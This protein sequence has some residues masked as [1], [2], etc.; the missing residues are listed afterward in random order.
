MR[1]A[2]I[3]RTSTALFTRLAL[4]VLL[5]P[6]GATESMAAMRR[7]GD[8]GLRRPVVLAIVVTP[9]T[10]TF[11]GTIWGNDAADYTWARRTHVWK[12]TSGLRAATPACVTSPSDGA[13]AQHDAVQSGRGIRIERVAADSSGPTRVPAHVRL[14]DSVNGR[15]I[16]LIPR[17]DSAHVAQ[18]TSGYGVFDGPIGASV[19]GTAVTDSTVWI[20]LSGAFPEGEGAL[21]GLFRMERRTGTYE[22]I[23]DDS[24]AFQEV[25]GFA[26]VGG[27]LWFGTSVAGEYAPHA[28]SG[29]VRMDERSHKWQAYDEKSTPIPDALIHTLRSDGDIL[30]VA[31][32]TGLAV[33]ELRGGASAS[34]SAASEASAPASSA[35]GG[36]DPFARWD[37]TYFVPGFAGDSLVFDVGTKAQFQATV[38]DEE[39]YTFAQTFALGHERLV[40]AALRSAPQDSVVAALFGDDQSARAGAL[41]ADTTLLPILTPM[42][43]APAF[44]TVMAAVA[45]GTLGPRA[46]KAAVDQLRHIYGS[47]DSPPWNQWA[48]PENRTG[49]GRSLI[50]VG[51]STPLVWARGALQAAVR[52]AMPGYRAAPG[53]VDRGAPDVSSACALVSTGRDRTGLMLLVSLA[54]VAPAAQQRD[55]ATAL[56]KYNDRNAWRALVAFA[57]AHQLPRDLVI[58]VLAPSAMD[59]SSV[60]AMSVDLIHGALQPDG[61]HPSIGA[62]G[63]TR[64]L[65][66]PALAPDLIALLEPGK[67]AES[68]VPHLAGMTLVALSGRADAPIDS[69]G[70]P[71]AARF[72]WWKALLKA[73]G[74]KLDLVAANVGDKAAEAWGNRDW[75]PDKKP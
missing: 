24:L 13:P 32:E 28:G 25:T 30:A 8:P 75:P 18:L 31:T 63:A 33:A 2:L 53:E 36:A 38:K 66:L 55:V 64:R 29:I 6:G 11:C 71:P 17:Y 42:L 57:A 34:A 7:E 49:L 9:D 14:R 3:A 50:M 52:R 16:D 5:A 45:I 46:P 72:N 60:V 69:A 61:G 65:R 68:F 47:L 22:F 20:A 51:D 62:I 27:S 59:D 44:R 58:E 39:R 12:R 23:L 41:L 40:L 21:G 73:N 26:R 15:T 54:P 35:A 43:A 10:V 48:T 37:V 19:G 1:Y 56:A 74:G 67:V 4:L 70:V